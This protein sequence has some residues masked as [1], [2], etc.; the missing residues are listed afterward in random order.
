MRRAIWCDLR[1]EM[2]LSVRQF[3]GL[4]AGGRLLAAGRRRY[5]RPGDEGAG[6]ASFVQFLGELRQVAGAKD[7]AGLRGLCAADVITGVDMP[8]GPAELTKRMRAGGWAELAEILGMGAAR[9]E[10]GFVLPYL[11]GKFPEDLESTEH[12]V[13]V[14]AGATLRAAAAAGARMI[15]PL[16]FDILRVAEFREGAQWLAA[17]RLDGLK[18]WVAAKDV[19]SLGAPRVFIEKRG[20]AWKITAWGG[21]A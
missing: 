13:P 4:L 7:E 20:G 11:F 18:G 1:F 21:G 8:P 2:D 17:E 9:Y 10:K 19:R 6:D 15:S 12:V 5:L 16:D 3:I 14:R